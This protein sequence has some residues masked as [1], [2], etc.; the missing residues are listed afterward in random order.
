ML[1]IIYFAYLKVKESRK[2]RQQALIGEVENQ[3]N[4]VANSEN[5]SNSEHGPNS[6]Q[7]DP[8]AENLQIS[9]LGEVSEAWEKEIFFCFQRP[10]AGV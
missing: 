10:C 5:I 4:A 1:E 8:Q 3:Q 7:D 9:S 6:L 2:K